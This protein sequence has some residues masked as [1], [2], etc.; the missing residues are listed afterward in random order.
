MANPIAMFDITI[1]EENYERE[2]LTAL[3][4]LNCSRWAFQLEEGSETGYRHYQ[5]RISLKKKMRFSTMINKKLFNGHISATSNPTHFSGDE[6][7]VLK[8]DTRIEGP[9]TDRDEK[10]VKTRQLMIFEGYTLRSY[11]KAI[12]DESVLFNMRSINLIYDPVGN[13]GKSLLSEYLEFNDL[14]EEVPPY[15]LMDDIF[16]WVATRPIRDAYVIDMPRGMKKDKLAD[17]YS[18]IEVIKNGVAYDKRY[19]AHKV[20]FNRPRIFVFTNELPL[21]RLMSKDRWIIWK[22]KPDYSYEIMDATSIDTSDGES[23]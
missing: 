15:R 5:L 13:C 4:T 10:K 21:F 6:F 22:I 8:E 2:K 19:K 11:Q 9:W 3:L 16:Q 17:F 18:G 7:Y 20:R 1:P 12:I 23:D 14:A